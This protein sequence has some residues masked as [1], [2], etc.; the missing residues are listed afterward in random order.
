[1]TFFLRRKAARMFS[2]SDRGMNNVCMAC[3]TE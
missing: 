1:M 3:S 2:N